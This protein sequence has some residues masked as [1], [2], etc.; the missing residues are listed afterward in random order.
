MPELIGGDRASVWERDGLPPAEP[1]PTL[2]EVRAAARAKLEKDAWDYLE[3]GAGAHETL[4]DNTESFRRWRFRPR[5]LS[6]AAAP[7]LGTRF[8]GMDLSMPVL[9][10]PFGSDGLFHTDGHMA[11]ARACSAAGIASVVPEACSHSLETVAGA[12]PAAARVFQLHPAGPEA[13]FLTM[14]LRAR[15]AGYG[16]LCITVDCPT[17][18]WRE[19]LMRSG[20]MPSPALVSGNYPAEGGVSPWRIFGQLVP[21]GEAPWSW[22]KLGRLCARA[23]LPFL[24]KG[25]L[26]AEDACRSRDIGASGVVVSNHGGRQ[27]DGAPAALDV[28]EE[29]RAALGPAFPVALD[30]GVWRGSDIL[31]ARALGADVVLLGRA[32]AMGLAAAGEAG[33]RRVL[34]LIR[35]E[36]ATTMVLAGC[37]DIAH[38]ARGLL[39]EA[40]GC[41]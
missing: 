11:V 9:S 34:E 40:P 39:R 20:F 29:V 15:A 12:A 24:V 26:T 3:G 2:A 27:L 16:A 33:V 7:R 36:L 21:R 31:K 25:V 22:E 6:G 30:G 41:R 32:I 18:G 8:L 35:G 5:M 1:F 28:I 23:G 37:G 19:H 10:A 4:H 38:V 17:A 14:A 13:N